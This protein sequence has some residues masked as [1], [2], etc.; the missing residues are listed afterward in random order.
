M[1]RT[2]AAIT[3]SNHPT[4]SPLKRSRL[5]RTARSHTHPS[6]HPDQ[7]STSKLPRGHLAYYRTIKPPTACNAFRVRA[8]HEDEEGLE[9]PVLGTAGEEAMYLW[10]LEDG[11]RVETIKVDL[12][13]EGDDRIKVSPNT[14]GWNGGHR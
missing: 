13:S 5:S 4:P 12:E 7:P 14:S 9:R 10:D 1:Y 2:Q 11:S 8:D 6:F 3:R